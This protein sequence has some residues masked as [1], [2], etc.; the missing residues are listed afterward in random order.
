MQGFAINLRRDKFKDQRVRR[1]LNLAF[2][3]EEMNKTVFFG[4][5]KRIG[6][7]FE[8]TELAS[9][10][11]PQG[12]EKDILESVKDKIPASVFTTAYTNPLNGSPQAVRDNLKEA[13]RLLKDAGYTIRDGKRVDAKG[14]PFV[15]ELLADDPTSNVF[16]CFG[17]PLSKS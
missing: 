15:I 17:S 13:D 4:A 14:Q 1:A 7:Y 9:S 5:Y 2:D 16:C 8:G 3:F 12:L 10:A 11:L 6:S